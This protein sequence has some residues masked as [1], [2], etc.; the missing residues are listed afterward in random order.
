MCSRVVWTGYFC[1]IFLHVVCGS[2][3]YVSI[4]YGI[5]EQGK[6]TSGLYEQ[7]IAST[8]HMQKSLPAIFPFDRCSCKSLVQAVSTFLLSDVCPCGVNKQFFFSSFVFASGFC[9]QCLL[10]LDNIRSGVYVHGPFL[11]QMLLQ[12]VRVKN[13]CFVR[14]LF[15]SS[16]YEL[17]YISSDVFTSDLRAMSGVFTNILYNLCLR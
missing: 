15:S 9:E 8:N 5:Y 14:F 2:N 7:M 1:K 17:C 11:C 6:F 16:L 3:H 13:T 10:L 4:R 12:V